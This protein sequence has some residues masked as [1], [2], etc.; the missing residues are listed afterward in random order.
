MCRLAAPIS[1]SCPQPHPQCPHWRSSPTF[2]YIHPNN[3]GS[4]DIDPTYMDSFLVEEVASGHMDSPYSIK[5]AH[6]I[7]KGHFQTAPLGFIEKPGSSTLCLICHHLKEDHLGMSTNVWIN[8]S[9]G[10]TKFYSVAHAA[11]LV[12]DYIHSLRLPP[13]PHIRMLVVIHMSVFHITPFKI[14]STL[15]R[16]RYEII[17]VC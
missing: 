4:A 8:A 17:P 13:S 11:H 14:H 3:L 10:A 15:W 9:T 7:F 2:S 5:Q 6:S 12:S 1:Q 16:L